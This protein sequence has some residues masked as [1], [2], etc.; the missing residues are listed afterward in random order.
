MPA[1]LAS[2]IMKVIGV[3][4][5]LALLASAVYLSIHSVKSWGEDLYQSG[6]DAGK[7]ATVSEVEKAQLEASQQAMATLAAQ[8]KQ[9][10]DA[11]TDYVKTIA[12]RKPRVVTVTKEIDRYGTTTDGS[13]LC[14][15]ASGVQLLRRLREANSGGSTVDPAPASPAQLGTGLPASP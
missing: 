3:V 14:L 9:G 4:L 15:D 6:F 12:E 13:A 10:N 2:P 11:V 5:A 7:A 8:I 1:F